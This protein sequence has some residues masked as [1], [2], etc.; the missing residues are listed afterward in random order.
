MTTIDLDQPAPGPKASRPKPSRRRRIAGTVALMLLAAGLG[1]LATDQWHQQRSRSAVQVVVLA[2]LGPD[3]SDARDGRAAVHL[4]V[5]NAG[6]APVRVVAV[7]L[8][9]LG[10]R[11]GAWMPADRLIAPG[12][13]A[14]VT[15]VGDLDC[16]AHP[17]LQPT[18]EMVTE[19][20]AH[21][22]RVTATVDPR[23]WNEQL[24]WVCRRA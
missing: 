24:I 2:H 5:V 10:M 11:P 8:P 17:T 4:D 15:T 16:G 3:G 20:G 14:T 1:G 21:R 13:S 19:D 18:V 7:N 9:A 6:S 22:R 12:R 23:V